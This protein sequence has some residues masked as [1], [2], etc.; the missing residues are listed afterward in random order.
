II[1]DIDTGEAVEGITVELYDFERNKIATTITNERGEYLFDKPIA[2]EMLYRVRASHENY[3]TD[4]G[5]VRIPEKSGESE[6]N[7]KIKKTKQELSPVT[8][9]R[10]VLGIPDIYFDLDKS[11]IRTDAEVELQKILTVMLEYPNLVL[12]IRSHT[13]SRAS[14]TYNEKLSDSRAKA[15]RQWLINNGIAHE[16]LTA[17]GYGE[18]QLVNHCAD[19]VI[20]SE[21]EH[22]QNRRSEFIVVSGGE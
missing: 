15:S 22:Q 7:L 2:C 18:T 20:C 6:L 8:D 10:F 3:S 13:D 5:A 9:L 16:R 1:N 12:E 17:K 14:H 11:N 4:E 19:G 21:E